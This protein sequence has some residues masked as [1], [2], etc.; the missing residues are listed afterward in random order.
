MYQLF[1]VDYQLHLI[2]KVSVLNHHTYKKMLKMEKTIVVVKIIVVITNVLWKNLLV[3]AFDT[4]QTVNGFIKKTL[5]I[6]KHFNTVR[7]I[8]YAI[9]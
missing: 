3:F 5:V 4:F 6:S 2:L 9:L 1:L 7:I 8:N